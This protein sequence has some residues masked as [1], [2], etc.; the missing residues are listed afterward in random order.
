MDEINFVS[1]KQKFKLKFKENIGPFVVNTR[2][3]E[4]EVD[5]LLKQIKFRL[6]FSWPYEPLGIMSKIIYKKK[7]TPYVHIEKKEID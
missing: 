2:V 6:S 3:A 4:K 5:N 7:L 1:W